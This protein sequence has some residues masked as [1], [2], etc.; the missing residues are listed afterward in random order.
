MN[1]VI[2]ERERRQGKVIIQGYL[3]RGA[4]HGI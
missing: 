3:K 4:Q 1:A 2:R